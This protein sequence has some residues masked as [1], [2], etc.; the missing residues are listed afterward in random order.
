MVMFL[1]AM[2]C[3]RGKGEGES[4]AGAAVPRKVPVETVEVERASLRDT[5][6]STSTV[7]SRN[8]VDVVSE[9]PGT[10]VAVDVEQGDEV[11][12]GT[13]LA[14]VSRE[15][16][17]LGVDSAQSAVSRLE[18]EVERL[19]P[20]YEKGILPR[21]QFEEAQYRLEEAKDEQRRARTAASD[22]RIVAPTDGVV[23]MRYVTV[24]QQVATGT[25]LFRV[26]QPDDLI[27]NVNLPEA[28]L[29]EIFEGQSAYFVSDAMSDTKFRGLVERISPVVDPRTGTVQVTLDV[30]E[31]EE[32][33]RLRPGMF[34]KTHIIT[35][36]REDVLT[37]PR[38]A[39]TRGDDGHWVFVVE[40]GLAER[41]VV[42]LGVTERTRV[43]VTSGVSEGEPVVVLGQD[44][45][46][47]GT[48]VEPQPRGDSTTEKAGDGS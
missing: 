47:D 44:G 39:V 8:A 36:T 4:D 38:R 6:V 43:E 1:C 17:D 46:K 34:V 24:G 41:R 5:V 31:S 18:R 20:L 25:P 48:A 45:L 2:G 7:D 9:I 28:A 40:D 22:K 10:V 37:V 13:R 14:R 16:L 26:V 12:R 15:E 3:D 11:T 42:E 23:A 19:R 27:V 29:G 33:S 35:A 32:A 21:Q 30:E